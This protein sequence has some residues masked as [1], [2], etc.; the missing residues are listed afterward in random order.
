LD[1]PAIKVTNKAND[2]KKEINIKSVVD[3]EEDSILQRNKLM[4]EHV[5]YER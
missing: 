2:I 5:I 4:L 3:I 1:K